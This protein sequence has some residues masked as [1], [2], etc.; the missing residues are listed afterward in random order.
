MYI[1][2][3]QG[4][5][6]DYKDHGSQ[7]NVPPHSPVAAGSL[8]DP[9][10]CRLVLSP[11]SFHAEATWAPMGCSRPATESGSNPKAGHFWEKLRSRDGRLW[12][13]ILLNFS[14]KGTTPSSSLLS[15]SLILAGSLWGF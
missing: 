7:E 8:T 11:H 5:M 4:Q 14:W 15:P 6:S 1:T 13:E 12:L 3:R 2:S 9:G 10:P